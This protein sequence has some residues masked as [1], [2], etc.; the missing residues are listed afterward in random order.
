MKAVLT[1]NNDKDYFKSYSNIFLLTVRIN[2]VYFRIDKSIMRT[3]ETFF[4]TNTK[5]NMY[6]PLSF[7]IAYATS[8]F[9]GTSSVCFE[10][11]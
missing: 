10:Y 11:V 8:T 1:I 3:R 9:Q 4:F 5:Q 6:K 2:K 7:F